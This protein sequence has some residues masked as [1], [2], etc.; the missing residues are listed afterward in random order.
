ME[1][2][3]IAGRAETGIGTGPIGNLR[4][5]SPGGVCL[6]SRSGNDDK[7]ES[8]TKDGMSGLPGQ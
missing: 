6:S 3:A 4:G 8:L 2:S 7:V 5:G 1:E